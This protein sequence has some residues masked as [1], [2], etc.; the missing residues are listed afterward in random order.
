M[1]EKL[2]WVDIETTGLDV[3]KDEPVEIAAVLTD[4]DLNEI[5]TFEALIAPSETALFR[6]VT[7]APALAM[8]QANGLFDAVLSVLPTRE[9]HSVTAAEDGIIMMLDTHCAPEDRVVLSGSGVG[10]FD[11][12]VIKARMPMLADRLTYYPHDVGVLRREF[13]RATGQNLTDVNATKPHR[14]MDDVRLH[15]EESRAFRT[16]LEKIA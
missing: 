10:T 3:E 16:L 13:K 1:T 12:R 15:I 5:D 6:L 4:G 2:L 11:S 14:A 8:H 9:A 7:C